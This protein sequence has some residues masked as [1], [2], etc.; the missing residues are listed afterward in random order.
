MDVENTSIYNRCNTSSKCTREGGMHAILQYMGVVIM[1]QNIFG[2]MINSTQDLEWFMTNFIRKYEELESKF[3]RY[4]GETIEEIE[5][6]KRENELYYEN[7][8]RRLEEEILTLREEKKVLIDKFMELY[9]MMLK[10]RN[11]DK[12]SVTLKQ[13]RD[14]SN[15]R[16][17]MKAERERMDWEDDIPF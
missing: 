16:K 13:K 14:M 2:N 3:E 12:D 5:R 17:L 10:Y 15:F 11:D 7:E 4:D 9:T 1:L 8:R 6:D